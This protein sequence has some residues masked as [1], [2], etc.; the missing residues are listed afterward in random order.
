MHIVILIH[1]AETL[2]PDIQVTLQNLKKN[3]DNLRSFFFELFT[4][5][6]LDINSINNTKKIFEGQQEKEGKCTI[7][8]EEYL[9]ECRK[10]YS[11]NLLE[12]DIKRS[13]LTDIVLQF[14]N[15]RYGCGMIM[16]AKFSYP[17]S[18]TVKAIFKS[19]VQKFIS[20]FNQLNLVSVPKLDY[21]DKSDYG[22]FSVINYTKEKAFEIENSKEEYD[23]FVKNVPPPI[24]IPNVPAKYS[25]SCKI[26]FV[27]TRS[28][29]TS[30]LIDAIK[31]KK[32]QH[33]DSTFKKKI[34]FFDSESLPE[35]R[36]GMFTM[37]H[38]LE[39]DKI[40][41]EVERSSTDYILCIIMRNYR[42]VNPEIQIKVFC[43]PEDQQIKGVLESLA[44][45]V[46]SIK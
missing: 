13:V 43:K 38:M 14:K 4:F 15:L 17:L 33:R 1:Y 6:L 28:K 24:V 27:V 7:M 20:R 12:F 8:G 29:V 35:F 41:N 36:M 22:T 46:L 2:S 30:K 40:Q 18:K 26:N 32:R 25:A 19:K 34:L 3:P 5:W 10:L 37:Q 16:Y 11:P 45:P 31:E 21:H 42:T 44:F 9:F 23:V 39:E